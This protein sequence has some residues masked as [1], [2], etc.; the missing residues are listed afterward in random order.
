MS[1]G[2]RFVLAGA[3]AIAV[4]FIALSLWRYLPQIDVSLRHMGNGGL[5]GQS[6]TAPLTAQPATGISPHAPS[7]TPG[8][9]HASSRALPGRGQATLHSAAAGAQGI[10]EPQDSKAPERWLLA[11][12][13]AIVR[14]RPGGDPMI[15][16]SLSKAP[17]TVLSGSYLREVRREGDWVLILSPSH[18]LGWISQQQVRGVD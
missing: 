7:S 8:N 4:F 15:A 11:T 14:K 3:C 2:F 18:T 1:S 6:S 17:L 13:N 5:Q 12:D 16:L 10:L 9:L